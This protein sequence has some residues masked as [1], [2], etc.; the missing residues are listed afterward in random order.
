MKQID[1]LSAIMFP[2]ICVLSTAEAKNRAEYPTYALLVG[3]TQPG[4][5]QALLQYAHD[6]VDNLRS[7]LIELG[8]YPSEDIITLHDPKPS[9]LYQALD[10]LNGQ[11][12]QH[13]AQNEDAVFLFY[14]SGHA[15]SQALN[16]GTEEISLSTLRARF[17]TLPATVKLII[18][19]ACQTGAISR[20][21]GAEPTA[22]FSYNSVAGLNTAGMVVMS[23]S[24]A[25]ELSQESDTL[26]GS[27]FTHHLVVGLR[28]AA[29]TNTDGRITLNEAY[30]YAYNNTLVDTAGTAVGKQHVTLETDLRG[31]GE[32]IL[33]WPAQANSRITLPTHLSAEILI[34]TVPEHAI[35]AEVHKTRGNSMSLALPMR[36]YGA[37]V[38][39]DKET[40]QC[41][42]E[43]KNAQS[44]EL[45]IAACED[46]SPDQIQ[47]KGKS[48]VAQGEHPGLAPE[49]PSAPPTKSRKSAHISG[50]KKFYVNIA[51]GV[52]YGYQMTNST[53]DQ[54]NPDVDPVNNAVGT[55]RGAIEQ[56]NGPVG[57]AWSGVPLKL[58]I[59]LFVTERL[60]LEISGR[61]DMY[62]ASYEEPISCWEANGK[63]IEGI[64]R[65]NCNVDLPVDDE[66]Y[67]I[68]QEEIAR[69]AIAVSDVS[70][71]SLTK[72]ETPFAWLVN[73]R[74]RYRVFGRNKIQLSIFTG[75]G[76]GHIKYRIPVL[77]SDHDIFTLPG[78]VNI[79][80]GPQIA[81]YFN[82]HFGI[83]FE[84][85]A[86]IVFGDGF[87]IN[88]D[89]LLGLGFG[90]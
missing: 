73:A 6:D 79:E 8:G 64:E 45:V 63:S 84:L 46:V 10:T 1:W 39:Q 36:K 89:A 16:L 59:G 2:M 77:G 37:L 43:R 56:V 80:F 25:N 81:F 52:G 65:I 70:G 38:S 67:T 87:A 26:G 23:S 14:Y 60:S 32:M 62:W 78:M 54:E 24:S 83:N 18:L 88:A 66:M 74:A 29:D 48:L 13:A 61:F 21:K 3:S 20:V 51:A 76:Y 86:Y 55:P 75:I 28:G 58:A 53:F 30:Q 12:E 9:H 57:M 22:R 11:L 4:K 15:R 42:I 17:K 68:F 31:K 50:P 7:V 85:P 71:K 19:D 72:K 69:Q 44:Q 35:I 49:E 82:D 40:K 90:F 41:E 34:F 27:F 5:D 47:F 33:T